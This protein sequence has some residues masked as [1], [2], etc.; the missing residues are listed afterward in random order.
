MRTPQ[1]LAWPLKNLLNLTQMISFL[2]EVYNV[3]HFF[4]L[5]RWRKIGYWD[6]LGCTTLYYIRHSLKWKQ[7]ISKLLSCPS[8]HLLITLWPGSLPIFM[9]TCRITL[10][11]R[12]IL[13]LKFRNESRQAC[14]WNESLHKAVRIFWPKLETLK[15]PS[16]IQKVVFNFCFHIDSAS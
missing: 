4:D 3:S 7:T 9:L 2:W 1:K 16:T 15:P 12:G 10:S 11:E 13:N 14:Q 8:Q 5:T 6:S